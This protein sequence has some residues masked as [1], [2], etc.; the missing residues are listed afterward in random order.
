[1]TGG[2]RGLGRNTALQLA[3]RGVGVILTYRKRRSSA[4]STL[5]EIA[6]IGA[7]AAALRHRC[8][9][10]TERRIGRGRWTGRPT[11]SCF[12][13]PDSLRCPAPVILSP[14]KDP[15]CQPTCSVELRWRGGLVR[16]RSAGVGC[17]VRRQLV[18]GRALVLEQ[19]RSTLCEA[20]RVPPDQRIA[21]NGVKP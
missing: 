19:L 3:R 10:S 7:Q 17:T 4:E 12:P 11:G 18:A 15:T 16:R 2:S 13:W 21:A 9:S 8:T 14:W 20:P 1:M 5:S 6:Q